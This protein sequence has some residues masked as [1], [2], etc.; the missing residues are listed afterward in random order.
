MD[1]FS[2]AHLLGVRKLH[3]FDKF[4]DFRAIAFVC[5]I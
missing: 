4:P 2:N 1:F 3:K 5:V